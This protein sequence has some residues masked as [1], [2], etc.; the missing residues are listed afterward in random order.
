MLLLLSVFLFSCSHVSQKQVYQKQEKISGG[1]FE[2]EEWKDALKFKRVSWYS[3]VNMHYEALIAP[4]EEKSPFRKWL[5]EDEKNMVKACT[6][7]FIAQIYTIDSEIISHQM[8]IS[9]VEK[10]GFKT[11]LIPHFAKELNAHPEVSWRN[12]KTY[13]V[14]GICNSQNNVLKMPISFPGFPAVMIVVE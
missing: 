5:S 4:L 14:T 9:Q 13:Q 6:S 7:F 11:F 3:E 10:A 8:F 12:L 1:V 2:Q